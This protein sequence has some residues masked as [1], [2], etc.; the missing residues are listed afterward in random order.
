MGMILINLRKFL[1]KLKPVKEVCFYT[2]RRQKAKDINMLKKIIQASTILLTLLI[3][4]P[5]NKKLMYVDIIIRSIKFLVERSKGDFRGEALIKDILEAVQVT[6]LQLN[7]L[8]N[9]CTNTQ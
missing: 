3:K 1:K 9:V 2:S 5:E 4:I 8:N 6:Q 7:E